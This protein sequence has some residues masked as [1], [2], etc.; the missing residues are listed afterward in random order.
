MHILG[1]GLVCR[2]VAQCVAPN[3]TV[4]HQ[5]QP[6]E[7]GSESGTRRP[8][9]SA[10]NPAHQREQVLVPSANARDCGDAP[11]PRELFFFFESSVSHRA[12]RKILSNH[13]RRFF[14]FDSAEARASIEAQGPMLSLPGRPPTSARRR[15][16][17][18]G[19]PAPSSCVRPCVCWVSLPRLANAEALFPATFAQAVEQS[20][21]LEPPLCRS[22]RRPRHPEARRELATS[23]CSCPR[24]T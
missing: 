1:R 13:Q 7:S 23:C 6:K 24:P 19:N 22:G 9:A 3:P 15:R 11:P 14:F 8:L 18:T 12:S 16:A 17:K 2:A 20:H 10:P 4:T 5:P 21:E